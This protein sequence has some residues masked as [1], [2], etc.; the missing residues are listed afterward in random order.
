M[1]RL[2]KMAQYSYLNEGE[3][4]EKKGSFLFGADD[5]DQKSTLMFFRSLLSF[6]E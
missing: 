4:F 5:S 6:I 2:Y 1:H 3:N